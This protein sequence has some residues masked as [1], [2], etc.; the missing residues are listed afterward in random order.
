MV[1]CLVQP[2]TPQTPRRAKLR[3]RPACRRRT[4]T[5]GWA[6]TSWRPGGGKGTLVA[7]EATAMGSV[8]VAG[9]LTRERAVPLLAAAGGGRAS[10]CVDAGLAWWPDGMATGRSR[11]CCSRDMHLSLYASTVRWAVSVM[12]RASA[13]SCSKRAIFSS[14]ALTMALRTTAASACAR[15]SS[16]ESSQGPS[17]GAP[18]Q[19]L[20]TIGAASHWDPTDA[21]AT[22]A[23]GTVWAATRVPMASLGRVAGATVWAPT[24]VALTSRVGA[25]GATV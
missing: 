12:A 15:E 9:C 10:V 6:G 22:E 16:S 25:L 23:G 24:L 1:W 7:A 14:Q 19:H 11:S 17:V 5:N 8:G 21:T 13:T 4:A 3:Q 2:L 18:L 20:G